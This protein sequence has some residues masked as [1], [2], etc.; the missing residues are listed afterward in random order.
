MILSTCGASAAGFHTTSFAERAAWARRTSHQGAVVVRTV[1]DLPPCC[2]ISRRVNIVRSPYPFTPPSVNPLTTHRW[3]TRNRSTGG[4]ALMTVEAIS[5]PQKNTSCDMKFTRPVVTVLALVVLVNTCAYRN[6][7]QACVNEKKVT[8]TRAGSD[9]GSTTRTRAPTRLQPSTRA[10]SSN[11]MGTD[12]KYPMS[13][14][15]QNGTSNPRY[16]M[17]SP[18][19]LSVRRRTLIMANM[20]MKS[21]E[22]GTRYVNTRPRAR[23]ARPGKLSRAMAYAPRQAMTMD[24]TVELTAT[25]TLLRRKSR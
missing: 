15:V 1:A 11:S 7:F 4:R 8:T 24:N 10:A 22:V 25:T 12:L 13:N 19:R 3:K 17:M 18:C 9:I 16:A 2:K 5:G 14:H 20:G 23:R 6:S 21:R